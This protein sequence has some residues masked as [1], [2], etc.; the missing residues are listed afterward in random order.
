M[1]DYYRLTQL[2]LPYPT[3][4]GVLL[5]LCVLFT[6]SNFNVANASPPTVPLTTEEQVWLQ[7]HP[8][9][10]I[11][12]DPDYLPYETLDK[13]GSYQGI[14]ADYTQLLAER[15]GIAIEVIPTKSWTGSLTLVK[16]HQADVL[17]VLSIT[18]KRLKFLNFT[19]QYINSPTVI[20]TRKDY[21]LVQSMEGF[22]DKRVALVESYGTLTE[23]AAS[24][25][26]I[27]VKPVESVT[28]ALWAVATGQAEATAQ[29]LA[30][31]NYIIQRDE[32]S[33]LHVALRTQNLNIDRMGIGVRKDWPELIPILNKALATITPAE[34]LAI[35]RAWGEISKTRI[36]NP[37]FALTDEEVLWLQSHPQI[38]VASNP[39]WA[40]LEFTGPDGELNGVS[41]DYLNTLEKV[42]GVQ[43]EP[44]KGLSWQDMVEQV[45]SGQ[46]D[47]L[48]SL[49]QTPDRENYFHFSDEFQS[50][51]IMIFAGPAV[52]YIADLDQLIGKRVGVLDS[53]ATQELLAT[54]HP[55]IELIASDSITS[56]LRLLA[57]GGIDA[58]VGNIVT[59][60]YYLNQ[61]GLTQIKVVGETPYRYGQAMAV[62]K[63]W[64]LLAS[65]LSKAL[66]AIPEEDHNAIMSRWLP[67][68]FKLG[69]DYR[70]L[71]LPA[72]VVL[73]IFAVIFYWNRR[74]A[75]EVTAR[76]QTELAL[77][78]QQQ[79]L[80]DVLKV[81]PS[82]IWDWD[83]TT[84]RCYCSPS[85]FHML[86][87]EPEDFSVNDIHTTWLN[88]VHPDD[89]ETALAVY[90]QC[91]SSGEA[92]SQKYR[93]RCKSGRYKW[94]L[95]EGQVV[96]RDA[97]G[98]PSR[99]I[100]A[101]VDIDAFK[102]LENELR[103]AKDEA[104]NAVLSLNKQKSILEHILS[105][106]PN[107]IFWKDL[108]SKYLG[109]N[110]KFIE[111]VGLNELGDVIG[112]SDYE[113][114][115]YSEHAEIYIASDK[116]IIA[117]GQTILNIEEPYNY[118]VNGKRQKGYVITSK[119]P[120]QDEDGEVFGV[121]GVATDITERKRIEKDLAKSKDAAEAANLAKS[122]FLANMSH[123]LRT[124]LN[125]VLGFSELMARDT[126][127]SPEH[128]EYLRVINSSGHHLLSVI[129]DVLDMSKIEAGHLQLE[130][131]PCD[132]HLLLQDVHD[133][134][135]AR[136]SD[137]GIQLKLEQHADLPRYIQ[138][139][140]AK[141][142]QILINLLSNAIR[143]TEKGCVVLH[144]HAEPQALGNFQLHFQLTDTGVGIPEEKIQTVFEAFIQAESHVND[145][146]GTGLGLT[147]SRQFIQLMGGNISVKS[148]PQSGTTF[149]FMIQA[150]ESHQP[151]APID[152][153]PTK[154][155]LAPNEPEWRIL[156]VEDQD[157]NRALLHHQLEEAGFVV[158]EAINGEQAIKQFKDYQPHL[159]WMDM[160]MPVMNGYEATR[161][162]RALP[163]GQQVKI[164]A[165]TAS[166]FK[167]QARDIL[168]VGCDEVL[169]KPYSEQAL[170]DA[171]AK[172]LEL[173]YVY[174][175]SRSLDAD[176]VSYK[177]EPEDLL[178]LPSLWLSQM[179]NA[180]RVGDIDDMATQVDVLSEQYS[181]EKLAFS[182]YLNDYQIE[183]LIHLLEE[184]L[185]K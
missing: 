156:I 6:L 32:L 162:I 69:F 140:T 181:T 146:E 7:N 175:H 108:S 37:T 160:N 83:I 56:A 47:M 145:Q 75:R 109:C 2:T 50:H 1:I 85:Y 104:E 112:K 10:K 95:D 168:A 129:N 93:L 118:F 115:R 185:A 96:S 139:D 117:T 149:R 165:L 53:Y 84:D 182:Q 124:P 74:L 38:K 48:T 150:K 59:T 81:S 68:K 90:D 43:F 78:A 134:F 157:N 125:A 11:V 22:N 31:A 180:A 148:S 17:P 98:K 120:L 73:L 15:L 114:P 70:Q 107:Q 16:N 60:T 91:I 39:N 171:M 102:Q 128:K 27:I 23:I 20:F 51:P 54:H 147:I 119:V 66:N 138:I 21:P 33:N 169:N 172:H 151:F 45:K 94:V 184:A 3:F 52:S 127:I 179:L 163:G 62:R 126:M 77:K 142:R 116:K 64:P 113:F 35:R 89:L 30:V 4:K 46:L 72:A 110:K 80:D 159:I 103:A 87:Y 101:H 12:V 166:A 121:L 154:P 97:S 82:G 100:G 55:D 143:F 19:D 5:F 131:H 132:L 25:P 58:F 167:E 122:V 65:I 18:Q 161:H 130:T 133:M 106:I 14:G 40:P 41:R 34:S 99:M 155:V 152:E 24:Y 178:A 176:R 36:L 76:K 67:A 42:L 137:K 26:N 44:A 158:H 63:D 86:C 105:N 123:E 164:L 13:A 79:H 173:Q 92:F 61:L 135:K 183:S 170:F 88:L 49:R 8:V 174:A 153:E 111:I 71:W 136:A 144:V 57:A 9:I 28:Q 29:S 177:L 141:L